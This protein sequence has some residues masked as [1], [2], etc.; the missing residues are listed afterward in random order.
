M[1][2]TPSNKITQ[3]TN[4]NHHSNNTGKDL[5]F[6]RNAVSSQQEW[7]NIRKSINMI[8][9]INQ[10]KNKNHMNISVDAEKAFDKVQPPFMIRNPQQIRF[11][12]NIPQH[13]K[14]HIR[15]THS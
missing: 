3:D 7:F 10:R 11:R 8:H 14:G 9:P 1:S 5:Y 12:G 4:K 15:K 6:H 2:P 13:N